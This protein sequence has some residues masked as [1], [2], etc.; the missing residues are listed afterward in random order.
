MVDCEP[1]VLAH[2]TAGLDTHYIPLHA[3]IVLV[4]RH[5]L[6]VGLLPY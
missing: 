6:L 1:F 2:G 5:Y 3:C 4:M